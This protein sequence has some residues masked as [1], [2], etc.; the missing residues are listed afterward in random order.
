MLEIR[1]SAG[2]LQ[3]ADVNKL[4]LEDSILDSL[5]RPWR[6]VH[7]DN[8]RFEA[9]NAHAL[10]SGKNNLQFV[11]YLLCSTALTGLKSLDTRRED[12][13]FERRDH[14]KGASS[15]RRRPV[16]GDGVARPELEISMHD[17]AAEVAALLREGANAYRSARE[18][19]VGK[20]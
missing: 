13:H 3:G 19:R 14:A 18:F 17:V 12:G 9:F 2:S 15:D 6:S 8:P 4:R 16:R 20:E 11:D 10:L 1:R 5:L 7:G